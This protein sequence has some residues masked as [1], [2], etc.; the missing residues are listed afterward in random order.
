[1][2]Y[3]ALANGFAVLMP[4]GDDGK[5]SNV[6]FTCDASADQPVITQVSEVA[7]NQYDLTIATKNVCN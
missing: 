2:S 3:L 1:M 7:E 4:F 6:I 5:R